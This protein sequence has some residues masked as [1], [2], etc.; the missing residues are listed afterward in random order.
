MKCHKC[1]KR[2]SDNIFMS[3]VAVVGQEVISEL[4]ELRMDAKLTA[5]AFDQI[6]HTT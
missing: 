2:H 5:A 1:K 3:P 6:M 4:A